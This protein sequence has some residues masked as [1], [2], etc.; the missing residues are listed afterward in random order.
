MSTNN[1]PEPISEA[2]LD[3]HVRA[4][5]DDHDPAGPSQGALAA[6]L[7]MLRA[8][9]PPSAERT[10]GPPAPGVRRTLF[11]RLIPMT[12]PQRLAAAVMLTIGGLALYFMLTLLGGGSSVAFADVAAKF[13][14][15][16]TLSFRSTTTFPGRPPLTSRTY[17]AE[18]DRMRHEYPTGLVTIHNGPSLLV[19]TDV[20][21][22]ARRTDFDFKRP[23]KLPSIVASF[24]DLAK[25]TTAERLGEQD[26][27]GVRANGF[28]VTHAQQTMTV[29]ADA[30]TALPIRMI[31]TNQSDRGE[32]T[33]VMD[34]F[35]IDPVLDDSLFSLD[36]PEGYTLTVAAD[37]D[38]EEKD[39]KAPKF[40]TVEDAVAD[41]LRGY[42][43]ATR[44]S[45]PASLTNWHSFHKPATNP[46]SKG[47]L[48][49][50]RVGSVSGKLFSL[51]DSFHYNPR[52]ARL[53]DKDKI[54][55]WYRPTKTSTTYRALYGDLRAADVTAADLRDSQR[56][57]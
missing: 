15:A 20:D 21:R 25:S 16:R 34:Q 11:E 43:D 10:G 30:K 44:G 28:R 47:R 37:N 53:G 50:G 56:A 54:I 24:R 55:F 40:A 46:A 32:V 8:A 13:N 7:A 23:D 48:S 6:T 38:T 49:G 45:F 52:G 42:A 39:E 31:S 33:M 5:R 51:P 41:L 3:D 12:F 29:W 9:P 17:L 36:A 18:P 2:Q 22:T 35:E 19:I 14:A 27:D 4:L 57:Q 26:I 1:H